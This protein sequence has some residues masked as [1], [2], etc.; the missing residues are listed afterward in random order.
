MYRTTDFAGVDEQGAPEKS[1]IP[2]NSREDPPYTCLVSL[3]HM[4][5][6]T[7]LGSRTA[8]TPKPDVRPQSIAPI[9]R[10]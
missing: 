7:E 1:Q 9:Q 5:H 4:P 10:I 3:S 6:T 8:A 2:G